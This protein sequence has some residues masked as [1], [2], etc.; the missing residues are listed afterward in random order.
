MIFI[1]T[2]L[3]LAIARACRREDGQGLTEYAL[4][5]ALIAV[6]AVVALKLLG[7]H[8]TSALSSAANSL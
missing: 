8:V 6:A 4:V 1:F 5:L 7:D 3:Q 2:R